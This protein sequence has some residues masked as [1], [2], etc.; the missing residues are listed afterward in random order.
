MLIDH[1]NPSH[2][3]HSSK[4]AKLKLASNLALLDAGRTREARENLAQKM[5]IPEEVLTEFVHR[6]D[7]SRKMSVTRAVNYFCKAGYD[8][9]DKIR[10]ADPEKSSDQ[11]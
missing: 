10:N 6:A 4:L 8:T 1:A 11:V 5:G 7:I 3:L 2:L 9:F